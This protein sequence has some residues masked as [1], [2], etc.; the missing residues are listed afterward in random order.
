M[1]GWRRLYH[2][3][4][5]T[6]CLVLVLLPHTGCTTGGRGT[7]AVGAECTWP[8]SLNRQPPQYSWMAA[9]SSE[10]RQMLRR[11]GCLQRTATNDPTRRKPDLTCCSQI[12]HGRAAGGGIAARNG[13]TPVQRLIL[14]QSIEGVGHGS[15]GGEVLHALDRY[16]AG[17]VL[18]F[19]GDSVSSQAYYSLVTRAR[20][21][22]KWAV[23]PSLL[24]RSNLSATTYSIVDKIGGRYGFTIELFRCDRAAEFESMVNRALTVAPVRRP[25]SLDKA[26]RGVTTVSPRHIVAV[27]IGLHFTGKGSDT[28]NRK[29]LMLAKRMRLLNLLSNHFAFFRDVTPQHFKPRS[30]AASLAHSGLFERRDESATQCA[31]IGPKH[32]VNVAPAMNRAISK[33]ALASVTNLNVAVHTVAAEIGVAV[34]TTQHLLSGRHD[35]HIEARKLA[36]GKFVVDCTHWC[37]AVLDVFD[38]TL[39]D[40]LEQR[41]GKQGG[42]E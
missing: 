25:Q 21:S 17:G 32:G 14:R 7:A 40:V 27:N 29:L 35:A 16:L 10:W 28:F 26:G 5:A 2:V 4:L 13:T 3:C 34:Q 12:D 41:Y 37:A 30:G 9:S 31:A 18:T 6:I 24:H 22:S 20:V 19:V 8:A 39:L 11:R 38:V 15:G 42:C 36:H 33:A 1:G 23:V